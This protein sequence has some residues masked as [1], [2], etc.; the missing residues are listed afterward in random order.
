MAMATQFLAVNGIPREL[1]AALMS[2]APANPFCTKSYAEAM[3]ANGQQV[4]LLGTKR[5]GALIAGCYGLIASGYLNRCLRIPSLPHLPSGDVFWDG[6]LRFCS[7]HRIHCLELA[8]SF[9]S[10]THIPP[11][12]GEV[13]RRDTLEYVLDLGDPEWER[14]LARKHRQN[15]KRALE[16]GVTLRRSAGAD[17]CRE[18]VRLMGMSM[19][20]R[21]RRGESAAVPG[22]V[23]HQRSLSLALT[24]KGAGELF[25][26]VARGEVL[27]SAI[28]LRAAEGAHYYT[29]GT[30]PEGMKCGASHF[31]LYSIARVLREESA[32]TFNLATGEVPNPGLRLFKLRFGATPVSLEHA[33]FYFGSNLR[34]RLTTAAHSLR[35]SGS[36]FLRRIGAVGRG[37]QLSGSVL[38]PCSAADRA[39]ALW[40]PCDRA[41]HHRLESRERGRV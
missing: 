40:P 33:T 11:L 2:L 13:E 35:Q 3:H 15:I 29:A 31:L 6:L 21:G 32:R 7:S 37:L 10:G 38:A 9:S 12:P 23:K 5:S 26:A 8:N 18:H 25:Q 19:E 39:P 28:V 14:N 27:S 34:R 22:G 17:P 4:W 24:G 1:A 20:R 41:Q 36:A 16:T 30:S